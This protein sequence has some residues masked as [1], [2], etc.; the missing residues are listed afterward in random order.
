MIDKIL[1][2]PVALLGILKRYPIFYLEDESKRIIGCLLGYKKERKISCT[3]S[4]RVP[5]EKDTNGNSWFLDH[6]FMEKMADMYKKVNTK[7]KLVG[8]YSETEA[9]HKE[10]TNISRL[11]FGYSKCP[12]Y[13]LVWT[14]YKTKGLYVDSFFVRNNVS[15][16]VPIF[17]NIPATIGMLESEEI[18]VFQI[19]K[20]SSSAKNLTLTS[21]IKKCFSIVQFYIKNVKKFSQIINSN[22]FNFKKDY[23][24]LKN[25]QKVMGKFV[26]R[27]NYKHFLKKTKKSFFFW[28]VS[29]LI[30]IIICIQEKFIDFINS[31]KIIH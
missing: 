7:E 14:N 29:M 26:P 15:S 11:F 22:N 27:L 8:W 2:H 10:D 4:F 9:L 5:F 30:R 1:I 13:I 3:S 12:I 20:N 19:L 28:Y 17:S 6:N 21:S 16:E 31:H 25:F 24:E 23:I 18:G